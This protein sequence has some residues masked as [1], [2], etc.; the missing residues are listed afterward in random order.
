MKT[1]LLHL[2]V[3]LFIATAVFGG[4]SAQ[5]H[6]SDG[7]GVPDLQ[8]AC[9]RV[10]GTLRNGCPLDT[11][12]ADRDGDGV[13]D[14]VDQCPDEAGSGFTNGCPVSANVGG[15]SGPFVPPQWIF[16]P[17]PFTNSRCQVGVPGDA[18][19]S[20][21]VRASVPDPNAA[22]QPAILG[23]LHPGEV[24]APVHFALDANGERWYFGAFNA[25]WVADSVTIDNGRCDNLPEYTQ[26]YASDL[27]SMCMYAVDTTYSPGIMYFDIPD[28]ST[29]VDYL[30]FEPGR[31]FWV[32]GWYR[33]ASDQLYYNAWGMFWVTPDHTFQ[34][35][36]TPG[37]CDQTPMVDAN[38][39][40]VDIQAAGAVQP[41]AGFQIP[42]VMP[43][44]IPIPTLDS[45]QPANYGSLDQSSGFLP[46]PVDVP[47][48]AGGAVNAGYLGSGCNGFA[49]AAPDFTFNYTA[50]SAALLRFYLISEGDTT[51]IVK[52]PNGLIFC[53]DDSYG[54]LNPTVDFH[55]PSSGRYDIWAGSFLSDTFI[56]GTLNVTEQSDQH[57]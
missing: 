30:R 24:F 51:L 26:A 36:P 18:L 50:G 22:Q 12:A 52:A 17:D 32:A 15:N 34:I 8:D 13:A 28:A 23:Q 21:N 16:M 9:P 20:V 47:M 41:P 40:P 27:A 6:D 7:D 43:T 33:D 55:N 53:D 11:P 4:V 10:A 54:T 2:F 3:L 45:N 1:R 37:P 5:S 49:S 35:S 46:D 14:F 39:D 38:G 44:L 29:G 25:G 42:L 31:R 19:V 48:T 57:P 56:Q